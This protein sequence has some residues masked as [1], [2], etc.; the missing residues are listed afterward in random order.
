MTFAASPH[1]PRT[2]RVAAATYRRLITADLARGQ[3]PFDRVTLRIFRCGQCLRYV[4][5]P[6]GRWLRRVVLLLDLVWTQLLMGAELP[7]EV[8]AGP[9][10]RLHHG[11]RGIIMHP[12]VRL[13]DNVRVYH[14]VTMGVR[15]D[16]PAATIGDHVF[17]GAGCTILGPV[18]LGTRT[19]VGAHAVVVSDTEPGS[20]YVGIPARRVGRAV[21]AAHTSDDAASGHLRP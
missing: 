6:A 12:T 1:H 2:L 13:G 11:G 10:L 14:R 19:K 18:T 5:S 8:W 7:H 4:D 17:L 3:S 21:P 16:R 9:G 20:T 15:D